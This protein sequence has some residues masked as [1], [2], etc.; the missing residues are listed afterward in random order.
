M[1]SGLM[2]NNNTQ[3]V[4]I[5]VH[6]AFKV[7]AAHYCLQEDT[8]RKW[9]RAFVDALDS[10]QWGQTEEAVQAY[11]HLITTLQRVRPSH[12]HLLLDRQLRTASC[13]LTEFMVPFSNTPPTGQA[14]RPKNSA[15]W[16][17]SSLRCSCVSRQ[18]L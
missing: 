13:L 2:L 17:V 9:E 6:V 3:G 4:H 16:S 8:K 15:S 7:S 5:L 14:C 1:L 18:A 10:D 11:Q 12:M